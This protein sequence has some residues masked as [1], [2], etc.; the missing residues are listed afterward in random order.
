MALA[1]GISTGSRIRIG[2]YEPLKVLKINSQKSEI[3]V[4]FDNK[5]W[6]LTDNRSQ[7]ICPKVFV[8]VGLLKRHKDGIHKYIDLA[9][10]APKEIPIRRIYDEPIEDHV[11]IT[12]AKRN[13]TIPYSLLRHAKDTYGITYS[14]FADRVLYSAMTSVKGNR[15]YEDFFF[16][17]NIQHGVGRLEWYCL[18]ENGEMH[19]AREQPAI[20]PL[21]TYKKTHSSTSFSYVL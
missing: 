13:I 21:V 20:K 16:Q 12:K 2:E 19:Y 8:F 11:R 3:T 9:F 18:G 17:V 7:E 1:V 6:I 4:W 14:S 15:R 5:Q 10:E